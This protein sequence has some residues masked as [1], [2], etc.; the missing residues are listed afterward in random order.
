MTKQEIVKA[1]V[2]DDCE[3]CFCKRVR[4]CWLNLFNDQDLIECHDDE[5][6]DLIDYD[7][8]CE[9]KEVTLEVVED[10]Q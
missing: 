2:E 5:L 3:C 6:M 10:V 7:L 8:Y 1:L 4:E 9:V